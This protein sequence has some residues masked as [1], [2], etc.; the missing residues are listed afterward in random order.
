MVLT[1]SPFMYLLFHFSAI[2]QVFNLMKKGFEMVSWNSTEYES[3]ISVIMYN[4]T[5]KPRTQNK[6]ADNSKKS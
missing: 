5:V 4:T 2:K 6:I 1:K 3:S